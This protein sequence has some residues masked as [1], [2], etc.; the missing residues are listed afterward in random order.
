MFKNEFL[1]SKI[2][3]ICFYKLQNPFK[4]LDEHFTTFIFLKS[5]VTS[6]VRT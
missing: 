3:R 5:L 6:H 1:I 2:M 4:F